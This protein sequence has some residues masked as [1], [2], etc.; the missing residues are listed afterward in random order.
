MTTFGLQPHKGQA[1]GSGAL[2][3]QRHV[4]H[5]FGV[6]GTETVQASVAALDVP[7]VSLLVFDGQL[8]TKQVQDFITMMI[9][10]LRKRLVTKAKRRLTH[11]KYMKLQQN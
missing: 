7:A 10:A 11:V 5:R 8:L 3:R 1:L 2:Q 4:L 6:D 9:A